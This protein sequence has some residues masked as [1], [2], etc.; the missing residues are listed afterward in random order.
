MAS[1]LGTRGDWDL[2]VVLEE[3]DHGGEK[4]TVEGEGNANRVVPG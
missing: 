3:V 4:P 1:Y 2:V